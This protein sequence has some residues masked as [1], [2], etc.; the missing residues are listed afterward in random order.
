LSQGEHS[1]WSGVFDGTIAE[2]QAECPQQLRANL[3]DSIHFQD[4]SQSKPASGLPSHASKK[5]KVGWSLPRAITTVM[6]VFNMLAQ[7]GTRLSLKRC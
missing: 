4:L 2:T 6:S 3:G 1:T 7:I 5:K